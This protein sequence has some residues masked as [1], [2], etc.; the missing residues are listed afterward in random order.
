MTTT[1]DRGELAEVLRIHADL[2]LADLRGSAVRLLPVQALP[3]A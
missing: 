2:P 1:P 3:V